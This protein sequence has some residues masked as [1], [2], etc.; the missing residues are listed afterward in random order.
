MGKQIFVVDDNEFLLTL[1][2]KFLSKENYEV[3]TFCNPMELACIKSNKISPSCS[4]KECCAHAMITDFNMPNMNGIELIDCLKRKKCKIKNIAV[5]T[6][7]PE[8]A[9]ALNPDSQNNIRF[10]NK[11]F[12][13]EAIL[14]WLNECES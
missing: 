3:C 5:M 4:V 8:N 13:L 12:N 6:A 7:Y 10:F 1:F 9:E 14:D 11:P 2:Q